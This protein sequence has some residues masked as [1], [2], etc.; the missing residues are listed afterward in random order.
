LNVTLTIFTSSCRYWDNKMEQWSS[1]GCVDIR[2]RT[3]YT[4]CLCNHLTS[5]ASG[6]FVPPNTIDWDKFLAF[7]LSQGYVCFAT[8]LTVIGLYLVFLIPARKA[9]KADAEKTGVTPIP[10]NDP[11]DTYCYEIHIHTGFIRGAGTSADVSIVLNGA[12]AD[13]DPRVLKDPKRKVF[14][15]GGVDAFLLTVPHV[16]RVFPLGNLKNIRLWHNNGG[17][18]PSWNLLRVMIQDL[19]TDQ[20]WWFVCDDWLAVDEGDGKIDRVIY[21]ATKNEL[22]KFNVLFATEVRKNLTDGHLWFSVVTRPANS[23]FTRVQRLTCCLSILLCTM[24]ANLMFYR[25]P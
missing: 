13:S 22:T 4:L 24:L 10:D 18:Y 17:A 11:R 12:V 5:F 1:A 25:S 3:D 14:K 9:D 7:D 19:Q 2:T 6:M 20:R 16:Y 15:T 23:P 21:P 8:V